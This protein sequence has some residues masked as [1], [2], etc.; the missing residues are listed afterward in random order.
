MASQPSVFSRVSYKKIQDD[1]TRRCIEKDN[2]IKALEEMLKTHGIELPPS[3]LVVNPQMYEVVDNLMK[4]GSLEELES[5]VQKN[6]D[7]IRNFDHSIEF[8]GLNYST[9]VPKKKVIPT[10]GSLLLSLFTFWLPQETETIDILA[11][12]TGRISPRK[13]TLLIGPPGSGKSVLLK[14]LAGRLRPLGG[15]KMAGEVYYDGD[16]IKSG[17]FLVGKVAD[18]VEQGD[19]HE[20]VLTVAE[21]ILFSW[22]CTSGGHHGYARARDEASAEMLNKDD[23]KHIL[24]QNVTISLGLNGCKDTLVGN[25][26]I[27]GVSGGQKRRVTIGEMMTCPR[28]IKLMDSIS[29]GLDTATTFDIIRTIKL[30]AS[31]VGITVVISLLQPPPDVYNQFDEIIL[32]SEGHIIYQGPRTSVMEYFQD[33]GYVCPTQVDEADFLQELPTPEGRRFIKVAGAPHSPVDLAAAWKKSALY[34]NLLSEMRYPSLED[35]EKLEM[36]NT[37]RPAFYREQQSRMYSVFVYCLTL[38]LI[39]IPYLLVAS[40]AFTLPFFYIVGFDNVGP[41]TQKFFWYWFF[42][43]LLQGTMLFLGEFYVSL[44]PNEA[45]TQI[46]AGLTNTVLGLFCGFLIGQQNFPSFWLFMYW[47][48]P[49]HYAL[50]GLIMTQFHQD[51]TP[52]RTMDG[53]IMTAEDY[54]QHVQF[55]SWSYDHVGLDVLALCLFIAFAVIGNYLCLAYLR[56]DK[57]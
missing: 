25:G 12:A 49:L 9:E 5:I 13:M 14:A 21:T 29:N 22:Q 41:V 51:T 39:E 23:E 52:I 19:T 28:P 15:A 17:K 40:L 42:N 45:T 38:L 8:H 3:E 31:K 32:L 57:R 50:E 55:P 53:S 11:N 26:M 54:I 30:I 18:Y 47:L 48:D 35:A 7:L 27:R 44:A 6:V 43:F 36:S 1:L 4:Q 20:A 16:N 33:L 2:Y 56:H 46:L 37:K 24:T 34:Q 10:V